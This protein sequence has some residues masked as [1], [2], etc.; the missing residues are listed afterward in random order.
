MIGLD[1]FFALGFFLVYI[2]S[3]QFQNDRFG[4]FFCFGI[5]FGLSFFGLLCGIILYNEGVC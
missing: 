4:L 1:Y 5:F 2:Q 3:G